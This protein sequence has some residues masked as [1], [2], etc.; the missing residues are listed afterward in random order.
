MIKLSWVAARQE[1]EV[2]APAVGEGKV[3]QY[4]KG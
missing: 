1:D 4:S 2:Y 3:A